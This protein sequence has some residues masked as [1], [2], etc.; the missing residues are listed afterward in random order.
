MVWE[1]G[2]LELGGGG[3]SEEKVA[4]EAERVCIRDDGTPGMS[5]PRR[6]FGRGCGCE[7]GAG[8]AVRCELGTSRCEV[9]A[10]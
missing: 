5:P 8:G 4:I 6:P 1:W 10:L 3:E 2:I 7:W 9:L